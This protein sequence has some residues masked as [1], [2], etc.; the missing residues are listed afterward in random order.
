MKIFPFLASKPDLS[1]VSSPEHFLKTVSKEYPIYK[2]KGIFSKMDEAAFYI[3]RVSGLNPYTGLIAC[4]DITT[5]S[6]GEI[7]GHEN[8]ISV[9]EEAITHLILTRR[10]MIKPILIAYEGHHDIDEFINQFVLKQ[11]PIMEF[12]L[13][14]PEELHQIWKISNQK[15]IEI[16]SWL[17]DKMVSRAYI[18]D[19]HHRAV[20]TAQLLQKEISSGREDS[21]FLR[22][23]C[24]FIPFSD[25]RIYDFARVVDY[26]K[27][28]D[29]IAFLNKLKDYFEIT[30]MENY[31]N[32]DKKHELV[33]FLDD[34]RFHLTWKQHV[35][36]APGASD[37]VLDV[38]LF[39]LYVL[40]SILGIKDIQNT[41]L[42][43]YIEGIAPTKKLMET[44]FLT[45]K[46]V[47]KLFP[48]NPTDVIKTAEA[49]QVLPPK[50]TWF[51][52]RVKNGLVIKEF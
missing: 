12:H 7:L 15:D 10:A 37:L 46:A 14:Q 44:A 5:I 40:E 26:S 21:D 8:T 36:N 4:S 29:G 20:V 13:D 43:T 17:F 1:K 16:I 25:L 31:S 33:L 39:N 42:V 45:G 23:L 24:M 51:E 9:K 6:D 38:D 11:V 34:M 2:T 28:L 22:L 19:G 35:I 3:H 52:P 18:A 30:P 47:F 32:P 27:K 50:S 41:E 48:L 49:G